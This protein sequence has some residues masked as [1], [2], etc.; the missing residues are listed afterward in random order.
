MEI[1]PAATAASRE[2][3]SDKPHS[4]SS[5]LTA[6]VEKAQD[7]RRAGR[8]EEA[9]QAEEARLAEEERE[10]ANEDIRADF[11]KETGRGHHIDVTA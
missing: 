8:A 5:A 2:L 1:G 4:G 6:S 11:A 10:K 3:S 7:E 9:K